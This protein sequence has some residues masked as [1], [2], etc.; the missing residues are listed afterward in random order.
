MEV[1]IS[2]CKECIPSFIATYF[3]NCFNPCFTLQKSPT[4]SQSEITLTCLHL[5]QVNQLTVPQRRQYTSRQD[6][7]SSWRPIKYSCTSHVLS[8][9]KQSIRTMTVFWSCHQ[10]CEVEKEQKTHW[11]NAYSRVTTRRIQ[12]ETIIIKFR[13]WQKNLC[14]FTT[15]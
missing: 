10:N 3:P 8:L 13:A 6:F 12:R 15:S 2:H 9:K 4:T 11:W 7:S 1:K 5:E 14:S